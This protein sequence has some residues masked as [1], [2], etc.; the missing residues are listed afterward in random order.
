VKS[1]KTYWSDN[2]NKFDFYTTWLLFGAWSLRF[3]HIRE[4][5]QDL[6]RYAN[7]LRLL[8]LLRV[9]KKLKKNKEVKFMVST[10]IKML[11]GATDILTL[12]G[13]TLY[14]FTTIAVNFFGGLLYQGNPKLKHS[15]YDEKHWY[16]FNFNDCL[17]GYTTWFTQLLCE[18]APEWADALN[19]VAMYGD[20]VWYIYPTF[21]VLGVAIVFEILK[22]F[23]IETYLALKEMHDEDEMKKKKR[24][25]KELEQK[26]SVYLPKRIN[27]VTVLELEGHEWK[28]TNEEFKA[29]SS[30][31]AYRATKNLED[32]MTE[33][34][35]GP[36]WGGCFKGV[37]EGDGWVRTEISQA[38]KA[39][40]EPE[41][42]KGTLGTI[43]EF[44]FPKEEE[45]D[46]DEGEEEEEDE[47]AL[48]TVFQNEDEY[49]SKVVA[50]LKK[51][52][53]SLHTK[54]ALLPKLQVSIKKAYMEALE[55]KEKEEKQES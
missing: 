38:G 7:I 23:T 29:E 31:L 11:E 14:F 27:G 43:L 35:R 51:D 33:T 37:D 41:G 20:F 3:V 25:E 24:R 53:L 10:V 52:K 17:M 21:Y 1:G 2:S 26:R 49:I 54:R 45:E 42:E 22:A 28:L 32:K 6:M 55:E 40:K 50:I 34:K 47:G 19:R 16:V 30:T 8:R 46:E 18:Y 36:K 44:F 13:V 39:E 4:L 12:L 48:L 15:D 5:Q 9:A